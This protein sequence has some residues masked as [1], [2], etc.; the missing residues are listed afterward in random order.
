VA[1]ERFLDARAAGQPEQVLLD[2][3]NTGG[4]AYQRMLDLLPA[5]ANRDLATVH[6]QLGLIYT[7]AGEYDTALI[8]YQ[9]SIR[10]EEV[11]GN[12]YGAG[13]SRHTVALL[14]ARTGRTSD[15]LLYARAALA[16]FAPYG[17]GATT[18]IEKVRRFIAELS[19]PAN[20]TPTGA[21]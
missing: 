10:L 17:A 7:D 6:H 12:R 15:A 14:F 1:Y 20:P 5:D 9:Q 3:L 8:H 4:A 16:D 2:H 18:N 13:Q 19:P 11:A 21:L